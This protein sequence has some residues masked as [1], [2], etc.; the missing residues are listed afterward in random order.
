[1]KSKELVKTDELKNIR[2]DCIIRRYFNQN[3]RCFGDC[4]YCWWNK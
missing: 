3:E 1:L 4:R 2:E